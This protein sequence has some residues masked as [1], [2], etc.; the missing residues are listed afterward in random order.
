MVLEHFGNLDGLDPDE[1]WVPV[2][3][4]N[5]AISDPLYGVPEARRHEGGIDLRGFAFGVQDK[6]QIQLPEH[7]IPH[8]LIK[9]D[10]DYYVLVQWTSGVDE[11]RDFRRIVVYR[12]GEVWIQDFATYRDYQERTPL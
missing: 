1:K 2:K 6:P 5:G 3:L 8:D 12:N 11:P 7:L 10:Q 9:P 4:I